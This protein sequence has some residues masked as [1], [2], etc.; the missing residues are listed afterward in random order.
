MIGNLLK[1]L[2]GLESDDLKG[3]LDRGAVIIDVRTPSEFK[4][5]HPKGAINIPLAGIGSEIARIKKMGKPVVTCCRSGARSGSAKNILASNGI[6]VANGG[7]WQ[8]VQSALK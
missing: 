6:E 4:S 2:F 1:K 7:P 5:G 3:F 8:N